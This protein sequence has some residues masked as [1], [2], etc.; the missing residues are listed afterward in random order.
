MNVAAF[1]TRLASQNLKSTCE[2]SGAT[3]DCSP[4]SVG[5]FQASG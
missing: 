4:S 5:L 3:R 1:D 2:T